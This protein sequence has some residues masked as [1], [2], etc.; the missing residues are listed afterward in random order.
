MKVPT[1]ALILARPVL[2]SPVSNSEKFGAFI[3]LAVVYMWALD[4]LIPEFRRDDIRPLSCFL[5]VKQLRRNSSLKV[6]AGREE[7][8]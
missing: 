5:N 6:L 3:S 7:L 1:P 8:C 2:Q 4:V